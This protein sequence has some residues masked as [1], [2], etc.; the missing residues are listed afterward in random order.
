M[1]CLV[2]LALV[3]VAAYVGRG[4]GEAYFRYYQFQ[5][6]MKQDARFE[7][8]RSDDAITSH[9]RSYADSLD[10]PGNAGQIR[11]SRSGS[12]VVIWSDYEE[13]VKLPFNHEKTL[14]FHPSS[15]GGF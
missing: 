5:D 10:L 2:T 12:A 14:R 3:V 7:T 15:G 11:I 13:T 8:L 6:A 1:G 9:L 4:F